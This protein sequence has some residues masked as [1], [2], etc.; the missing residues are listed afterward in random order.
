MKPYSSSVLIDLGFTSIIFVRESGVR[1]LRAAAKVCGTTFIVFENT[2]GHQVLPWC[3]SRVTSNVC[4]YDCL[5][6]EGMPSGNGSMG[7]R[8]ILARIALQ[9]Y[10]L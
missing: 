10:L 2:N 8:I 6:F 5:M 7:E 1:S 9:W 4:D 3:C